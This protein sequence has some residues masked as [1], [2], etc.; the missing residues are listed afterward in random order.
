MQNQSITKITAETQT[1]TSIHKSK[2]SKGKTHN[3]GKT[4]NSEIHTIYK[5]AQILKLQ[6]L[7]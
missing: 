3:T 1:N 6:K 2:L 4:W 5:Y 7:P